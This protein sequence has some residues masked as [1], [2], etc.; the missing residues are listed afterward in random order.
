VP[1][2]VPVTIPVTMAVT[3][4]ILIIGFIAMGWVHAGFS[5]PD[6]GNRWV[7]PGCLELINLQI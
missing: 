1:V 4:A 2:A 5:L 6:G 3:I 7:R